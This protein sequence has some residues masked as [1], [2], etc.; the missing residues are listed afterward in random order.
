MN[1]DGCDEWT[2]TDITNT[3]QCDNY[4]ETIDDFLKYWE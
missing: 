3:K 4:L 2:I 1:S